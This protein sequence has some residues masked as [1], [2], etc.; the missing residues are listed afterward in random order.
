MIGD[1]WIVTIDD[2]VITFYSG[3]KYRVPPGVWIGVSYA[4]WLSLT[5]INRDLGRAFCVDSGELGRIPWS[6]GVV[7][8]FQRVGIYEI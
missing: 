8:Q 1:D 7:H 3:K 6:E 2:R 4:P 5:G